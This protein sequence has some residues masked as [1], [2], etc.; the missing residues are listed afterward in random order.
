MIPAG[1]QLVA[2]PAPVNE[3]LID[4]TRCG[5]EVRVCGWV[6]DIDQD[7]YVGVVCGCRKHVDPS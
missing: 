7:T 3:R 1:V 5:V 4:C 2:R 6:D